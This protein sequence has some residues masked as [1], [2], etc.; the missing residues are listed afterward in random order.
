[1]AFG[2]V[3][4]N[5]S[6]SE[7]VTGFDANKVTV[8]NGTKGTFSGSGRDYTLVVTPTT[9]A[10]GTIALD[11]ITTGITGATG[12]QIKAPAQA[13]QAFN[14]LWM[15]TLGSTLTIT[16]NISGVANSGVTFKFT[17]NESVTGFDASKITV[18]NGTKGSFSGNGS[19]YTLSVTPIPGAQG[20]ITVDVS[21]VGVTDAAGNQALPPAQYMQTFNTLTV[22]ATAPAYAPATRNPFGITSAGDAANPDFADADGDGDL[23]LFIGNLGGQTLFFRN[24]ASLGSTTPAYAAAS[25]N[26][27]GISGVANMASPAF[28]DSD[29]DGDLDLFIGDQQ[30]NTIFYRNTANPGATALAYASATTNP[31]GITDIGASGSAAFAD[32][33]A[34]GDF[35]LFISNADG[36][37]L[38]FRNTGSTT[39]PAFAAAST[40]PFGITDVGQFASPAFADA[41][42]DGDLDLFIGALDG[43]NT[44]FFRNTANSGA[45]APAYAAASANPFG[46]TGVGA[47]PSPAFVDADG[48]GDLDLFIGERWG[49]TL[50]FRNTAPSTAGIADTIA[51][52]LTITD[53]IA[54][55]ASGAVTFTFTFSEPV[56]GFNASKVTVAN[57]SK[58]SFS[59]NGSGSVYT[60]VVTP[61]AGSQ[62]NITVDVNTAGVT[63]ASGNQ[64]TAP[65]QVVQPF[66]F[67]APTLAI[68]DNMAGVASGAVTFT[69][70]FSESV[71]GFDASKVAV[72]NGSKGTFSG[73]GSVYTLVV[74]PDAGAQGNITVDVSTTGVTDAAG[75][76]ATAPAQATQIFETIA[77]TIT[78]TDNSAGVVNGAV[79]FS[80]SFSETVTGFDASKVIVANG[81]KG[82]FSGSGSVYTLVVTP[83]AGA[84]DNITVDVV[85]TGVTDA[86]GNQA[87]TPVQVS[88]PFDTLAPTITITDNM[89]G[90]AT[91]AVNFTFTF[92]ESVT[93][94]DASKVIVA[95]G[96]KG[97]FSG[98][99]SVYTLVVT[100][101]TYEEGYLTVDVSTTGVTD[102]AGNQATAPAQASQPFSTLV[103]PAYAAASSNPFGISNVT[104]AVSPALADIDNDGDLD[105]LLGMTNGNTLV[106]RNT[107]ASGSTATAYAAASTNPFGISD[108]GRSARVVLADID[109]DGDF[110]LVIGNRDGDTLVF[111]NTAAAGAAAPAY[112]AASTNPF[113]ISDAGSNASPTF[114]DLD[115]DGDL[116]LV[117]GNY[118]GN[119]LMFRNNA[120]PGAAAP[121]YES[122][123]T[124]P[125]NISTVGNYASPVFADLDSDSDLDLLI[126]N[127]AGATLVFSNTAVTRPPTLAI[128]D[129]MAGVAN[130]VLTFIFTFSHWV[131]GF[132]ASKVTVVNGTK[133]TFSGSGSVYTLLVTPDADEE[134]NLT[135]DVNTTG[136]ID[137]AGNQATA[138]AQVVQ[139][140][141]TIIPTL[142][143]T[144]NTAAV[145]TA[146]VTFTFT[147]SESVTG[148]DASKVM[149]ANGSKGTFSGSGSVYTLVVIPA[150]GAQGDITVDVSTTGVTDAAGNQATAPAQAS[151][152]FDILAPTVAIT[153]DT[154]GVANGAVSFTFTFS[155]SVTGF[156]ASKVMVANGSKGTFSGSGSVY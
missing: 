80:F 57:G 155:E 112:A 148:F 60:L 120:A 98:S 117:I 83:A 141:D 62:G 54:G 119:T 109:R 144:D 135:V 147:F 72:A 68:T 1:V 69:F 63:D 121:A 45:I 48:D 67:I 125:F 156:D 7:A 51:P 151:Q 76:Q 33:D 142:A 154:A 99:G 20:N 91:G 41:D 111:R 106:F 139:P 129:N 66:D 143:I 19:V 26:P 149:V 59:S 73:S 11:V 115:G 90:V 103:S 107:A 64:A 23:D 34:D 114:A 78:I 61:S 65:A 2:D 46:I 152:P 136:V 17:F 130:G 74:T 124:N 93:G 137:A 22:A 15:D 81:S 47:F 87:T 25:N 127:G 131:T 52:T 40:N 108:V 138:P 126:G 38:F 79:L 110:D 82:T 113:G 56:N 104:N 71:T 101:D 134:G 32:V 36:N 24:T 95:N 153:D 97:T 3:T 12:N 44:F 31:F 49:N 53:N 122:A 84:Q 5:F 92:S 14:T 21:T 145:A 35:D 88:Q 4:F 43:G 89:A 18:A 133:G 42:A 28:V 13:T 37:T 105:L 85:T 86:A 50:F 39:A 10:Q 146:A 75:N 94:F 58:G 102:A 70:T 132:D 116:D 77:P 123:V 55:V 118:D 140:F 100:P 128:T 29:G 150:A 30:G 16:D 96:S 8:A 27:F 9:G 6:F